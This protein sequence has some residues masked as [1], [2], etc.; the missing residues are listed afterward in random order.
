MN[1]YIDAHNHINNSIL[2]NIY[3]TYNLKGIKGFLNKPVGVKEVSNLIRDI[4]DEK[5]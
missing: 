4:L 1:N 3:N 2:P 5:P